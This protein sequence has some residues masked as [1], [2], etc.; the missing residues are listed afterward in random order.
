MTRYLVKTGV[1][2]CLVA[3][4]GA[5]GCSREEVLDISRYRSVVLRVPSDVAVVQRTPGDPGNGSSLQ[6]PRHLY[7]FIEYLADG[8]TRPLVSAI[9]LNDLTP[10]SWTAVSDSHGTVLAYQRTVQLP[11]PETDEVTLYAIASYTSIPDLQTTVDGVRS[12]ATPISGQEVAGLRLNPAQ[13]DGSTVSIADVYAGSGTLLTDE[14]AV[15]ET[16]VCYH[17]A[18]K[19]DVVYNLSDDFRAGGP[20]AGWR[21]HSFTL[22]DL[23]TEGSY[24]SPGANT[25]ASAT[26]QC[27]FDGMTPANNFYGRFDTYLFQP[28]P[29]ADGNISLPWEVV[30]VRGDETRTLPSVSTAEK[31]SAVGAAY[32]RLDLTINGIG[33]GSGN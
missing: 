29:D 22:K 21:V 26:G 31:V 24:F 16:I 8:N 32:F 14:N 11:L 19:F 23:L 5:A 2:L 17:V 3:L 10:D 30:L 4:L 15:N 20:Y 25:S 9:S 28:A 12:G 13:T 33:D 6:M 1:V 27:V 18:A 7:F